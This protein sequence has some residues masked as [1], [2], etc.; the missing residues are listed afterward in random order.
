[1]LQEKLEEQA[2]QLESMGKQSEA[3]RAEAELCR[4]KAKQLEADLEEK[5]KGHGSQMAELEE[6]IAKVKSQL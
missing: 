1:M 6:N 2:K 4:D 5:V 3:A